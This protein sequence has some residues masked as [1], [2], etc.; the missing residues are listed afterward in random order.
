MLTQCVQVCEEIKRKTL[1][2]SWV[3][4]VL[5][6]TEP[7][8]LEYTKA[9]ISMKANIFLSHARRGLFSTLVSTAVS[10]A[11][12]KEGQALGGANKLRFWVDILVRP[13]R[14]LSANK[15]HTLYLLVSKTQVL[16]QNDT[17]E[18]PDNFFDTVFTGCIRSIG[19]TVVAMSPWHKPTHLTRIWYVCRVMFAINAWC[20]Q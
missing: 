7:F 5:S 14:Q 12:G 13:A 10:F 8:G 2:S 6:K 9:D 11:N 18:K 15:C 4:T 3:D 16:D 20:A 19:R 17:S 1:N